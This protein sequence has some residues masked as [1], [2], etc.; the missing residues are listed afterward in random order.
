MINKSDNSSDLIFQDGTPNKS[1]GMEL[2][3]AALP[4]DPTI[5]VN[6]VSNRYWWWDTLID[7]ASDWWVSIRF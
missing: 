1:A 5:E 4:F 3:A 6:D 2:I 7:D